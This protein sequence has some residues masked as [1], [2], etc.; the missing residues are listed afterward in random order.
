[1]SCFLLT[2]CVVVYSA[3]EVYMLTLAVGPCNSFYYLGHS[4][5][6]YDDDDELKVNFTCYSYNSLSKIHFPESFTLEQLNSVVH[7]KH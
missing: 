5:N 3:R 6:V 4:K 1:V 2:H 7:S